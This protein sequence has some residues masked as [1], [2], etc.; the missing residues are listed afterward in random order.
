M[1]QAKHGRVSSGS[2]AERDAGREVPARAV[3]ADGDARG[4][5]AELT[6]VR[7]RP[8]EGADAVLERRRERVLR[9]LAVA[10]REDLAACL[11]R[12]EAAGVGVRDERP[13]DEPAAVVEDEQRRVRADARRLVEA[14]RDPRAAR[15][16]DRELAHRGVAGVVG[17][18]GREGHVEHAPD[19]RRRP[20]RGD[21]QG[22]RRRPAHGREHGVQPLSVGLLETGQGAHAG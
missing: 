11:R 20:A 16:V 13:E 7:D 14:G 18:E 10:D 3:A 8:P 12:R 22:Q 1:S 6:G 19:R 15:Q 9:R 17:R 2:T 4:V 5:D 21:V